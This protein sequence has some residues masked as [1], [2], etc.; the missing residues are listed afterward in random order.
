MT[1]VRCPIHGIAY[2]EELEECPSCVR[3][4]AAAALEDRAKQV[5]ERP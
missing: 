1:I 5:A 3:E 2:D 4:P